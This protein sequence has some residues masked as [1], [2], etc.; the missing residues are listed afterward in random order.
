MKG[1]CED[2]HDAI[3]FVSGDFKYNQAWIQEK[4]GN[5]SQYSDLPA[6]EYDCNHPTI[7]IQTG[8]L[9]SGVFVLF[10]SFC[11]FVW[12]WFCFWFW[13]WFF[14]L[15]FALFFLVYA[16]FLLQSCLLLLVFLFC[17]CFLLL[18][19]FIVNFF[20]SPFP[21][22]TLYLGVNVSVWV[23]VV[24]T[25]AKLTLNRHYGNTLSSLPI[26]LPRCPWLWL[27]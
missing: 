21:S 22:L 13:F 24:K 2:L 12:F 19:L 1:F 11:L 25:D 3:Q 26:I 8:R 10:L 17:C 18:V 23:D 20:F 27:P 7:C 15:V 5:H 9:V 6:C 4:C 14:W 16:C